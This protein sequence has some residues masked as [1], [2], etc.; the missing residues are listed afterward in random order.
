MGPLLKHYTDHLTW[1]SLRRAYRE[2]D[3]KY[4][5]SVKVFEYA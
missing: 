5:H 4:L 3:D 2:C 1:F